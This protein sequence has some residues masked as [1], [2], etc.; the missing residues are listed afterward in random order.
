MKRGPHVRMKP[1]PLGGDCDTN[2]VRSVVSISG[3][4]GRPFNHGL[5]GGQP[6]Y[7]H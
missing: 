2:N 5:R 6:L 4:L 3:G 7:H 1:R